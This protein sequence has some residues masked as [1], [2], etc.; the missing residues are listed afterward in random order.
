MFT[1]IVVEIPA[2]IAD[3]T[4]PLS[5]D[6]NA[7]LEHA[8][9][10]ITRIE[11]RSEHLAG[12]GELL[13]RSEAVASSK[14]EHVYSSLDDLARATVGAEAAAGA[15]ST[16]AASRA[17]TALAASCAGSPLT[18]D[19]LLAAHHVLLEGDLLE[20]Q[21]AD[22]YRPVQNW[23][24]G[25]DFSPRT[26]A[27][28]PPPPDLVRPLID[29]LIAFSART[30]IPVVAQA[31]IVHGQFE[32]IHPFTDG[33]GRVGRALIGAVYRHRRMTSATT[34]PV[35]AAML[36]NTDTYFT[37]LAS[38]RAGDIEP[39]V[40]YVAHCTVASAEAA[41]VTA[42][43][44]AELPPLWHSQVSARR[45]S[46]ARTLVDALLTA[47]VLDIARAEAATGASRPRAYDA[48]DHLTNAG[49]LS[50]ITGA[51]RSRVWVASAVMDEL[52]ALEERIGLRT[53]PGKDW[54]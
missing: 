30:D 47:P 54:R 46:S 23:V 49:V 3:R 31:A 5:P 27:H 6:A 42:D 10:A 8:V 29:D 4:A 28:V 2:H 35:A 15:R 38:Y 21:Y 48:L 11:S 36:A 32:A 39:L 43:R 14:I 34:V 19:A 37:H 53:A 41:I 12:L 9:A 1:E 40:C 20:G 45:G 25:S 52:A 44:L 24:G 22:T 26:A 33:N 50:E 13:V 17:L 16:I 18:H 7:E 51:S